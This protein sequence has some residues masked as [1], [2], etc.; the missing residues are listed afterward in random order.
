VLAAAAA[1]LLSASLLFGAVLSPRGAASR[2][3]AVALAAW[4]QVVVLCEVLSEAHALHARGF[5]A[6]HA[7]LLAAAL[8]V[9]ELAGRPA[10]LPTP[11]E[12]AVSVG[13]FMRGHPWLAAFAVAAGLVVLTNVGWSFLYEPLDG[14]AN[15]YHL[16]RAYYWTM[17]GTA[18]HFPASDYRLTQMPPDSSFLEAWVFGFSRGFRGLH[19]FQAVAGLGLGVGAAGLARLAGARRSAA[20][21]AGLLVLAFP[22]VVLQMGTAQNDLL[23][24][25]AGVAAVF[26]GVRALLDS[27]RESVGAGACFGLAAG[28][29]FGTKLTT[30]FLVPGLLVSLLALAALNETPGRL[31]KLTALGAWAAGGIVLLGAYNAVLNARESGNPFAAREGFS[32]FY[33]DRPEARASRLA[34]A[35]RYVR[36]LPSASPDGGRTAFGPLAFVLAALAP[37]AVVRSA[38]DWRR[39]RRIE[40]GVRATLVFTALAYPMAFFATG[41]PFY[42]EGARFFVPAAVLMGAAA[43]PLIY[44]DTGA[45]TYAAAAVALLA[46]GDAGRTA[47][48]GP[49]GVRKQAY[50]DAR[51]DDG[52]CED[53]MSDLARRLPACFPPG[54]RL[55]IAAEYNDTVFHLFRALPAFDFVPVSESDVPRL[56]REGRIAAAVVGEFR[57]AAGQGVT[58]PGLAV[59][60][61]IL[62]VADPVRFYREHPDG[63]GLSGSVADGAVAFRITVD[64]TGIWAGDSFLLRIPTGLVRA[65]GEDAV[66]TLP[67]GAPAPEGVTVSCAGV[68]GA[69]RSSTKDLEIPIPAPCVDDDRVFA[70][71]TLTRPPGGADLRL[72]G[73]AR[74]GVPR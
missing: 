43:F 38:L 37:L 54:S 8:A 64:R 6:G 53:V 24:A 2:V 19:L 49:D 66:L 69:V 13:E 16:P 63:F 9:W 74:L 70:D 4:A 48:S 18:R 29:A 55:G 3:L 15:A 22:V 28:L 26:F 67:V 52:L 44:A 14:D 45:R 72:E 7:V 32:H 47:R 33:E 30:A 25:A 1:L 46:L 50:R 39:G 17:L 57:N 27:G 11:R 41:P 56:V 35:A 59:P 58:K 65:V 40:G 20:F 23:V 62:Y 10:P 42:P 68:T 71:L 51:F 31:R 36:I 12:S 60:R 73:E 34:N 5:L 21:F 61:N